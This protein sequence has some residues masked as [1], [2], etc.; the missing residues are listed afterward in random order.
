M[1]TPTLQAATPDNG[2]HLA[3][4]SV[5]VRHPRRVRQVDGPFDRRDDRIESAEHKTLGAVR[6][7]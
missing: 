1:T 2:G 7:N 6:V 5:P 3:T 4:A